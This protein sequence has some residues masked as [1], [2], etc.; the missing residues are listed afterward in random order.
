MVPP[1]SFEEAVPEAPLCHCVGTPPNTDDI[2]DRWVAHGLHFN[3]GNHD[4]MMPREG[5]EPTV[6]RLKVGCY[7]K[8]AFEA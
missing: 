6:S 7:S 1:I 8:L 2:D 4:G 3:V 5:V